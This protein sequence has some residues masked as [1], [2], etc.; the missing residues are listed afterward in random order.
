MDPTPGQK[1][2]T[3]FFVC[4]CHD[5]MILFF[6]PEVPQKLWIAWTWSLV[7]H[8]ML[9]R[10][11]GQW[12]KLLANLQKTH[13]HRIQA[14][15]QGRTAT[16]TIIKGES[17]II[18]C[19]SL[20]KSDAL[21]TTIQ[22]VETASLPPTPHSVLTLP[23]QSLDPTGTK[24][25]SKTQTEEPPP[26]VRNVSTA[27]AIFWPELAVMNCSGI[28]ERKRLDTL[29][30]NETICWFPRWHRMFVP[31]PGCTADHTLLWL[32]VPRTNLYRVLHSCPSIRSYPLGGTMGCIQWF[33]CM[34]W[35]IVSTSWGLRDSFWS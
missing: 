7:I 16:R 26:E 8:T 31:H 32:Q 5:K 28:W 19:W 22:H 2:R 33:F 10:P 21:G 17:C 4:W 30:N 25:P 29:I 12:Q 14:H 6:P 9:I 20:C 35:H 18:L 24:G 13:G 15:S 27:V 3:L 11:P 23:P 34:L 1:V